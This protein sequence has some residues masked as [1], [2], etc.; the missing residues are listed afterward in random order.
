MEF[1]EAIK[2]MIEASKTFKEAAESLGAAIAKQ[3]SLPEPPERKIDRR[4]FAS[5]LIDDDGVVR[6]ANGNLIT[7]YHLNVGVPELVVNAQPTMRGV[8]ALVNGYDPAHVD[9]YWLSEK[10][11]NLRQRVIDADF[12]CDLED[13]K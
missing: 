1:D 5:W 7:D 10:I 8:I 12:G 13:G 2:Q 4:V 3:V 9:P 11:G 6:D